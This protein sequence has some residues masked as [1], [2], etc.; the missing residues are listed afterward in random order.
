MP[1]YYPAEAAVRREYILHAIAEDNF[2]FVDAHLTREIA[3]HKGT[4]LGFYFVL[5]IGKLLYNPA[6]VC[7]FICCHFLY[8]LHESNVAK[9]H[10]GGRGLRYC[11]SLAAGVFSV[12]CC[13]VGTCLGL[14][15]GCCR[16]GAGSF[17][18]CRRCVGLADVGIFY[19]SFFVGRFTTN[20]TSTILSNLGI[21]AC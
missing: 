13:C 19:H 18:S 9:H 4:A 8:R 12:C 17:R 15:L 16:R 14:T 3:A 6:P 1:A 10:A 20:R 5:E 7:I 11:L 21:V 2:Y